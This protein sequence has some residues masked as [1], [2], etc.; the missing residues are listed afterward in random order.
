MPHSQAKARPRSGRRKPSGCAETPFPPVTA[1]NKAEQRAVSKSRLRPCLSGQPGE[2][3]ANQG[4]F[5]HRGDQRATALLPAL[6]PH[7][8]QHTPGHV[9]TR[10]L[11]P[12]VA[13]ALPHP[14]CRTA[15]L[16]PEPRRVALPGA[17]AAGAEAAGA[18]A[19]PFEVML[20]GGGHPKG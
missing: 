12:P 15:A 5:R 10:P 14:R 7:P 9:H 2:N 4:Y 19:A 18:E 3:A 13:P 6:P 8:P 17:G 1:A 11:L 20:A 16:S